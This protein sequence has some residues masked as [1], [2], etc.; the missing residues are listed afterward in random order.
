M[1]AATGRAGDAG[2]AGHDGGRRE[3]SDEST[4]LGERLANLGAWELYRFAPADSDEVVCTVALLPGT[5]EIAYAVYRALDAEPSASG[6]VAVEGDPWSD[7][8]RALVLREILMA[9]RPELPALAA[10]LE[11]RL[12]DAGRT[13]AT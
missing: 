7:V 11:I 6:S 3:V 4:V 13:E 2:D 10:G 9:Y 1:L 8:G 5:R 12:D